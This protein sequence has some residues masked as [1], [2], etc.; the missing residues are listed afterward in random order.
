M[1]SPLEKAIIISGTMLGSVA[2]F[3]TALT[4]I[5]TISNTSLRNEYMYQLNTA[6]MFFSAA[7]FGSLTYIAFNN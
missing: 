5:N 4:G 3:S 7:T 6:I 1:L 2:L